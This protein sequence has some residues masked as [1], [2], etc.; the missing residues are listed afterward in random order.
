MLIQY[1]GKDMKLP[2][3]LMIGAPKSGTTSLH[4]YLKQHPGIFMPKVK[5]LKFFYYMDIP[6]HMIPERL[7][8]EGT[9]SLTLE[10]Y[11]GY[12]RDA[13]HGQIIGEAWPWYMYTYR[14]T[15]KNIKAIYCERYKDLKIISILRNPA[16]RAWSHYM[17]NVKGGL[18]SV[19]NFRDAINPQ[20]IAQ[21]FDRGIGFDYT[22]IGMYY[23]QLSAYMKEF[24]HV[25]VFL[26]DDLCRDALALMKEMFGF[27]GVDGGFIPKVETKYNV[28]GRIRSKAVNYLVAKPNPL[29]SFLKLFLSYDTRT[30]IKSRMLEK[31]AEKED[32]PEG[33]RTE[34]ACLYKDDILK[35]QA[36]IK[37]DLSAWL[38]V[39]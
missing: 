27:L 38:D 37:K 9:V 34:L 10:D 6:Q 25:K 24:P 3:F 31:V 22:G 26:Y 36:L 1:N 12:F 35:L 7:I 39:S 4:Y 33:I 16:E 29:K 11:T 19:K 14:N 23:E 20:I 2:D 28:S 5:E 21:R 18:E 8:K 13:K 17:M 32:I 30:R 15:I